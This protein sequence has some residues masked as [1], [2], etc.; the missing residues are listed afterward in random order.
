MK[1]KQKRLHFW[2]ASLFIF[3]RS[4]FVRALDYLFVLATKASK[5][6]NILTFLMK[7]LVSDLAEKYV[8]SCEI[9]LFN[10]MAL[11]RSLTY[12][13]CPQFLCY[14]EEDWKACGS[15]EISQAKAYLE[16]SKSL[17]LA[18][19]SHVKVNC[20]QLSSSVD[21]SCWNFRGHFSR[22]F[23]FVRLDLVS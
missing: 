20:P 1:Y 19:L 14:S 21:P 4:Y 13:I 2:R 17:Q 7:K 5:T 18:Q 23:C 10:A 22:V 6:S 16:P 8:K 15:S 12:L 11:K 9:A 3:G